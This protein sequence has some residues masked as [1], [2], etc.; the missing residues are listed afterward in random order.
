LNVLLLRRYASRDIFR[1]GLLLQL[2]VSLVFLLAAANDWL[3][4]VGTTAMFFL[5][6]GC[7]GLTYP[8]AS[9][10][11]LAP[12]PH[13]AGTAAALIG[14]VQLGIAAVASACTGLFNATS[15]VPIVAMLPAT[16][17]IA[18][19]IF[20]GLRKKIGLQVGE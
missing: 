2:A 1:A 16:S 6:L 19:A 13:A 9:A 17:V 11:A 18:C 15:A 5:S 3:G 8:N 20:F 14:F 7:V 10:L 12:F 4:L